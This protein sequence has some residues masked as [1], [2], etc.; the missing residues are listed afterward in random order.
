MT[1]KL[2]PAKSKSFVL[3]QDTWAVILALALAF[4]VRIGLFKVP[5]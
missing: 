4:A 5:W 2:P 3:T 1:E